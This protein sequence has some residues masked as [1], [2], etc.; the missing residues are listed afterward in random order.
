MYICTYILHRKAHQHKY[1]RES[2]NFHSYCHR[3]KAVICTWKWDQQ[4]GSTTVSFLCRVRDERS[5]DS[6][7]SLSL[8]RI[9]TLA[10]L[11]TTTLFPLLVGLVVALPPSLYLGSSHL[12]VVTAEQFQVA[13]LLIG[14]CK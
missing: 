6:T 1:Q 12:T 10:W 4:R 14:G 2:E 7:V 3:F 5:D 13:V 8:Q 9:T 11:S